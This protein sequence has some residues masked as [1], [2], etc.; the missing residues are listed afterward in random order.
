VAHACYLLSV[1]AARFRL[2]K[3]ITN[4]SDAELRHNVKWALQQEWLDKAARG[5][6]KEAWTVLPPP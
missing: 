2:D 4:L 1:V 6:L 5:L 3:R